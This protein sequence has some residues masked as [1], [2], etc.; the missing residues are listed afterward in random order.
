MADGGA[1]EGEA[2]KVGRRTRVVLLVPPP[3]CGGEPLAGWDGGDN[4]DRRE[5]GPEGKK[6][7][8]NEEVGDAS[9]DLETARTGERSGSA[10]RARARKKEKEN[11]ILQD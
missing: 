5:G 3:A 7:F 8:A 10:R 1:D 11:A 2:A 6:V 9:C 4:L